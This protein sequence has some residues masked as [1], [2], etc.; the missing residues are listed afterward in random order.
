MRACRSNSSSDIWDKASSFSYI[1]LLIYA[2]F[3]LNT[4]YTLV[5]KIK[6]QDIS[7]KASSFSYIALLIRAHF[8]LNIFHT[9][10][11]KIRNQDISDIS[12]KS[13]S[14]SYI[15]LLIRAPFF[16][17]AFYTLVHKIRKQEIQGVRIFKDC[18]R[19]MHKKSIE[20]TL[21]HLNFPV[22]A[23]F[24]YLMDQY[25]SSARITA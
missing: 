6:N 14:F 15:A 2:S 17:N 12:N 9:L 23:I 4:F 5:H 7:N 24:Q 11:H 10:V 25:N 13:S 20:S 19:K 8:F 22:S 18:F 21:I 3:F 1:A 16:L